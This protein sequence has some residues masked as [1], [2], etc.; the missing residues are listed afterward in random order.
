VVKYIFS[1]WLNVD[2][3]TLGIFRFFLGLVCFL[4]IFRRLPYIEAFYSNNGV[5]SN[6]FMS[7]IGSKYST[8]AFSLLSSFGGVWEVSIFFYIALLFS[9]F[10]MIGYR[11][12]L[13]HIITIITILSI[14]NRLII[15]ENGGDLV[16]NNFLIW[17]AFFPLGKRFSFDRL[18]YL[19]RRHR[20]S[21]PSSLN[22]GDLVA[23]NEPRSYWGLAYFAC[24][25]QLSI[26]YFFNFMNKTGSTWEE[27]TSVYYFYHLDNFL[28]P[29]GNFI[30]EM[31][32]MP[33]WLSKLLTYSTTYLELII[34]FLILIPM[35][36]ILTLWIRRISM[37]AMI[38]FHIIIGISMYIG[39]F[40]W[41]MIAALLLLLSAADILLLK[42]YLSRLSSGPFVVFYDSDCGFCHQTARIIRRM[43]VFGNLTWAGKDWKKERPDGLDQLRDTTVAL[44]DQKSNQVHTRHV[45]FSKILA[46]LP[47]GFLVSWILIVPG[48]SHVSGYI[49]DAISRSRISISQLL[50]YSACNIPKEHNDEPFVPTY[51]VSPYKRGLVIVIEA[52]KTVAV[53][54]LIF[55]SMQYALV[56][57]DGFKGWLKERDIKPFKL[58]TDINQIS[59]Y[60]RMIQRWNMFSPTTPRSFKWVIIEATLNDKNRSYDEGEPFEDKSNGLYDEGERYTDKGN[61]IYN[62]GEFFVDENDN[63]L[64]D[65]GEEFKDEGNGVYD[66]GEPFADKPNG[67]HDEGE[68]FTDMATVI[69]LQTGMPPV[70]DQL[71]YSI[72]R[73]VDSNQFW[74]KYFS[75]IIKQNYKR[76]LPQLKKTIL[77][78]RNPVK[79]YDD[80]NRDGAVNA[81]DKITS[82]IAYK[83]TKSV[84]RPGDDRS[85]VK[86]V[87]KT[88][89]NLTGSNNKSRRPRTRKTK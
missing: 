82:I 55:A 66:E 36:P 35:I 80:L 8:K 57:N 38:G 28:T 75:R 84:I 53:G 34:P 31:N 25:L 40:S 51:E 24:L 6:F 74:R 78:S 15:L 48:L 5:A 11:T 49:Y 13:S 72:Y 71:D 76:Y 60:T 85:V 14:H 81:K 83:L 12:K 65:V 16:L 26:I 62:F 4:D 86:K 42:K 23:E 3:R 7:E 89:L 67:V 88:K 61:G 22:S 18:R 64:Y 1:G 63:A 9:F 69:D 39:M 21:T 33:L 46:S 54:V 59:K 70:Y 2:Y 37:L 45:A 17:S 19:L 77:S 73:Q 32:L 30:K 79:P 50:G 47:F 87:R 41:I 44:W 58:N 56:K 29:F 43:D 10:L 52:L 20:D 68:T 27:G